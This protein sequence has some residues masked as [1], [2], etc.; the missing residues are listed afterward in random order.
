MSPRSQVSAYV[1][2]GV[3]IC[4]VT[5]IIYVALPLE[6]FLCDVQMILEKRPH[7]FHHG[8]SLI[9]AIPTALELFY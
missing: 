1:E 9:L 6:S 5:Y 2:S 8:N 4:M 7:S 3:A